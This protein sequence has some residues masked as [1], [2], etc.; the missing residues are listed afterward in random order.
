MAR[1]RGPEPPDECARCGASVPRDAH[2]CPECGVDEQ[3]GWDANPWLPHD[4]QLDIP[5][6]LT[7]DY[8]RV[9]DG[10]VL[11]GETGLLPG[12]DPSPSS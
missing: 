1:R 6:Y 9:T 4:G 5:D 11:P 2:A 7:D 3:T 8:D 12:G 10:P